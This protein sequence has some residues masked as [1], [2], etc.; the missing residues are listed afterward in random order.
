MAISH[1]LRAPG[2]FPQGLTATSHADLPRSELL[3][4]NSSGVATSSSNPLS[5][6]KLVYDVIP[7]IDI[8]GFAGD[9]LRRIVREEGGRDADVVDADE[10]TSG[11]L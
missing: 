3:T 10:A 9:K 8:K 5:I 1:P 11:S 6:G 2:I 4:A 7:T